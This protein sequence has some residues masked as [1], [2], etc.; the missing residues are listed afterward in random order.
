MSG[1]VRENLLS[2]DNENRRRVVIRELQQLCLGH[3]YLQ[4]TVI[5]DA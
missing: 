1:V 4:L 5:L 2:A 3:K